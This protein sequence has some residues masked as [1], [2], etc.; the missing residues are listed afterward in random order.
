MF[1]MLQF[2]IKFISSVEDIAVER[3]NGVS[4]EDKTRRN[5]MDEQQFNQGQRLIVR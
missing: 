1:S 2:I 5:F 3:I 4:Y